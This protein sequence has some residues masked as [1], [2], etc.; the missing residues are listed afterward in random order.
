MKKFSL[1]IAFHWEDRSIN[2]ITKTRKISQPLTSMI[3]RCVRLLA[4]SSPFDDIKHSNLSVSVLVKLRNLNDVLSHGLT[5]QIDVTYNSQIFSHARRA[6]ERRIRCEQIMMR[7]Q[8]ICHVDT[9]FVTYDTATRC[10][11][12]R[13]SEPSSPLW[14]SPEINFDQLIVG[15]HRQI[16]SKT[17][18]AP[19]FT[20]QYK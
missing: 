4:S 16:A 13:P 11:C 3:F 15:H 5:I 2:T 10:W 14:F 20:R 12:Y 8:P 9:T 6:I 19:M 7:A 17:W 1:I 18:A